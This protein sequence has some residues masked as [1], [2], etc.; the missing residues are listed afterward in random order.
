[1]ETNTNIY[2][3]LGSELNIFNSDSK[4]SFFDNFFS[5]KKDGYFIKQP[6]NEQ[7]LDLNW[8]PW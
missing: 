3:P 2:Q 5:I 1:M 7:D 8:I 4:Y 6:Y